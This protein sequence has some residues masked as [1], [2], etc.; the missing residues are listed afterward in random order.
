MLN[1]KNISNYNNLSK[2]Q[3]SALDKEMQKD[4]LSYLSSISFE[5]FKVSDA[6]INQLNQLIDK[7]TK[8]E[9]SLF[10]TIFVSLLCG[11]LIGISVFFVIFQKNNLLINRLPV[12][13]NGKFD[14]LK[15]G[16]DLDFKVTSQ[17]PILT[18]EAKPRRDK[19]IAAFLN[20]VRRISTFRK[21]NLSMIGEITAL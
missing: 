9:G 16:Y 18:N 8:N 2:T 5:Q 6:D 14:F 15:N 4:D 10:N 21:L 13:F 3:K 11:L 17:N 7:K 20:Q 1:P 19:F 12:Q